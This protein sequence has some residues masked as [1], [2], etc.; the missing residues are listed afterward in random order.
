MADIGALRTEWTEERLGQVSAELEDAHPREIVRWA[1]ETFFPDITLA[2]SFGGVSGMVLLDMAMEINPAVSVF[3]VDTGFLFPETHALRDRAARR[4]GIRPMAFKADVSVEQQAALHGPELWKVDPDLCCEIRK[5]GPSEEAL[6]GQHAW[7]AGLR[8][9]QGTRRK[10][11]AIVA[12]DIKF[13][14]VKINPLATWTEDDVWDCIRENDVPYNGLH[15]RGYPSIGCTNCTRA[16]RP[17]EDRRAG[18]WSDFGDKVECGI[19]IDPETGK[20][21]SRTAASLP[22][23]GAGIA[24][25]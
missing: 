22:G 13:N 15:D 25:R 24:T 12:W 6:A 2:C 11:V 9:D 17:G 14:L 3:Y 18:R 4:Y 7:M 21:V 19:H 10:D 5:V 16:V 1:L 23:N 8:R 20:V